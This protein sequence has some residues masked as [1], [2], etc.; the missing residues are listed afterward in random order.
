LITINEGNKKKDLAWK[1]T[2]LVDPS[3]ILEHKCPFCGKISK[4]GILS[5][6]ERVID[7]TR[8]RKNITLCDESPLR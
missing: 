6:K 7:T 1:H 3:D 4:G 8:K 5:A 2:I